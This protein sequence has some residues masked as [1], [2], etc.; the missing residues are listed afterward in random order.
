LP[1]HELLSV[2][3]GA[4]AVIEQWDDYIVVEEIGVAGEI[5]EKRHGMSLVEP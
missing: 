5:A 2:E 4:S 1:G 3:A